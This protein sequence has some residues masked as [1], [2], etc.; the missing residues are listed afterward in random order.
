VLQ[1]TSRKG[2]FTANALKVIADIETTGAGTSKRAE[3]G[4][5]VGEAAALVAEQAALNE[6]IPY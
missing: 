5:L 4:D 3:N 1:R 6:E 2:R